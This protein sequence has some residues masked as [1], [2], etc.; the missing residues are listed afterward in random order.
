LRGTGHRGFVAP[1]AQEQECAEA[2][3]CEFLV[4]RS[5]RRSRRQVLNVASERVWPMG[6]DQVLVIKSPVRK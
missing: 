2:K 4:N 3:G 6:C 1:L 5:H